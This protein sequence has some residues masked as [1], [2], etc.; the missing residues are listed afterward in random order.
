MDA[1]S[2][3]HDRSSLLL[4]MVGALVLVAILAGVVLFVGQRASKAGECGPCTLDSEC[5]V[6]LTCMEFGTKLEAKAKMC[7]K[8]D[9]IKCQKH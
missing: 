9:S 8:A 1:L 2:R 6:G 3:A 5:G 7:A 4:R